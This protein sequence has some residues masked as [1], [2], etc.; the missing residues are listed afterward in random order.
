MKAGGS[1]AQFQYLFRRKCEASSFQ[2]PYSDGEIYNKLRSDNLDF[3]E[4]K[5]WLR[6]LSKCKESILNMLLR[7]TNIRN[8]LDKLSIFP[9]LWA[10]LQLGNIHKHLALHC[11]EELV[12]YLNYVSD[13]WHNITNYDEAIARAV[14]V[15]TVR[16]LQYRIPISQDA[17][18]IKAMFQSGK[19]FPAITKD[20]VREELENRILALDKFIPSI[21]TFH[22]D[23]MYFAVAVRAIRNWIAP[24]IERR[25]LGRPDT[26]QTVLLTS[27]KP[28]ES[29]P[30]Q[31][32]ED[33]WEQ[34]P[35]YTNLDRVQ[36]FHL[37]YRQLIL[38]ALR[39]FSDLT[40]QSPLQDVRG[41]RLQGVVD[42]IQVDRFQQT[43]EVLGFTTPKVGSRHRFQGSLT[44]KDSFKVRYYH[45]LVWR[46]GRPTTSTYRELQ[47]SLFDRKLHRVEAPTNN[48]ASSPL[49]T[50]RG[51][52]F[53]FI[54]GFDDYALLNFYAEDKF[55]TASRGDHLFDDN[56]DEDHS[57]CGTSKLEHDIKPE[58]GDI[59]RLTSINPYQ[60]T[61]D[62]VKDDHSMTGISEPEHDMEPSAGQMILYQNVKVDP[63]IPAKRPEEDLLAQANEVH[64]RAV[65][66]KKGTKRQ[67]LDGPRPQD[68][69]E[70]FDARRSHLAYPNAIASSASKPL[71]LSERRWGCQLQPGQV[72]P[73]RGLNNPQEASN[74]NP[75]GQMRKKQQSEE[76]NKSPKIESPRLTPLVSG[77]QV[78]ETVLSGEV[79]PDPALA[80]GI[81]AFHG[82]S[83]WKKDPDE[84]TL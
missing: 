53:A 45:N 19:L 14:D 1:H 20:S 52:L 79:D 83:T 64:I 30:I 7:H 24:E 80:P 5:D 65:E 63:V 44:K 12:N 38:A 84:E 33:T 43:A 2:V 68:T 54:R 82:P 13:I 31:E 57:I 41:E 66:E 75:I 47:T 6:R 26:L 42:S 15:D 16:N 69:Q 61:E 11:E 8:S 22:K 23:T 48:E 81:S 62:D 71:S 36:Q 25:D 18:E 56:M 9:G 35:A 78:G 73:I 32:M 37:A 46:G 4:R 17:H 72:A 40:N 34:L 70:D 58:T 76:V 59:V 50:Q 55:E 67:K 74:P 3:S 49:Y 60:A 10:G 51:M 29:I 28:K 21:E 39:S 27:F 77:F